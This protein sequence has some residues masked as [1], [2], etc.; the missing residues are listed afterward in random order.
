MVEF[1]VPADQR[2]KLKESEKRHKY[3]NLTI[4]VEK[5][6]LWN[7]KVTVMQ[8]VIGALATVIEGLVKGLEELELRTREETIQTTALLGLARILRIILKTRGELLFLKIQ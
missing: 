8:I 3:L 4:E 2:V 6:K 7:R 1:A 5:K